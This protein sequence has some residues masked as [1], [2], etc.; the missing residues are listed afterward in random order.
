MQVGAGY[1]KNNVVTH[2][3]TPLLS[4][5]LSGPHHCLS[6]FLCQWK[7][8][9]PFVC[10]STLLSCHLFPYLPVFA[11]IL[12]GHCQVLL[13]SALLQEGFPGNMHLLVVVPYL[14]ALLSPSAFKMTFECISLAFKTPV[15]QLSCPPHPAS[16]PTHL[17]L[18]PD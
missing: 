10:L 16:P 8:C 18:Q 17:P 5:V 14:E 13:Q 4:P 15:S 12:S 2:S 9:S 7:D 1:F 11:L 3:N 6:S